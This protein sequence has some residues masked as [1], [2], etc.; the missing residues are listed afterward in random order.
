MWHYSTSKLIASLAYPGFC[1]GCTILVVA[2]SDHLNNL[3]IPPNLS[4]PAK[5]VIKIDSCSGWGCTSCPGAALTHFPRKLGLKKLSPPWGVQVHPLHPLATPMNRLNVWERSNFVIFNLR[6]PVTV[7]SVTARS[8]VLQSC[9]QRTMPI[10]QFATYTV[11][12]CEL[13]TCKLCG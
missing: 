1:L 3:N 9:S 7:N 4:H 8:A 11:S 12:F 5:T 6:E 13:S 2:L 10:K